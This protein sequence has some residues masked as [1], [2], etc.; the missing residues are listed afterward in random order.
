MQS[1]IFTSCWKN[2]LVCLWWVTVSKVQENVP[3]SDIIKG[4]SNGR[5]SSHRYRSH[6]GCLELSQFLST[7]EIGLCTQVFVSH[8]VAHQ[9][10]LVYVLRF[11][12]LC[13]MSREIGLST[14][15]LVS[16]CVAHQ[17]LTLFVC[18]D[19]IF[20]GSCFDSIVFRF[21]F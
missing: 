13:C 8:C 18:V 17:L 20:I 14:Q 16:D 6:M 1:W 4:V 7:R 3:V 9:D 15:V 19:Q 11:L 5:F 12:W 21:L 10:R 2:S